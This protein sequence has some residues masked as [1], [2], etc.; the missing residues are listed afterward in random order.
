MSTVRLEAVKKDAVT[1]AAQGIAMQPASVDIWDKKYRLK[2]KKGEPVD[3]TID[4]TYKRVAKALSDAETTTEKQ[5]YWYERFLWALRRGAIPAGRITSNAGA[6]EHK[7]STS[8]INCTVSGTITDSMDGILDKVHE[9]GL[10]LKSGC[11]APGTWVVTD[12][13]LTTADLAV[14]ERHQQILS[15]DRGSGRFEMREI[16]EHLTTHVA[17]EDN[18]EIV[19]G[20]ATLTTS[21][22]HPVLVFR[23]DKTQWVR[24]DEVRGEDALVQHRFDWSADSARALDAWFAGAHLGDGSAYEKHIEYKPSRQLWASRAQ[25]AGK[26]LVFKIRA[27]ERE[28]VERYAQFFRAFCGARPQ[29]IAATTPNGTPV[30]DYMVASFAAS[31]A[32]DLIGHQTGSKTAHMHVPAWIKAQPDRHFLPFLA[33]LI[34]TDGTVS[35]EH[36]SATIAT[37]NHDFARELQALL[38]LFGVHG[39]LTLCKAR[40]HLLNGHEVR[41]NGGAMLKISDSAFLARVAEHMAD[42]GK[43]NR[44]AEHASTPGQYDVYQMPTALRAALAVECEALSAVERQ[45]NGFYHGYHLRDRVSRVWLDRWEA[46]F[47]ELKPLIAFARTLR[48]VEGIRRGLPLSETFFDFKVDG[49]NNYLAGN[50]GLL[51][52]HNCGIGY[53]FSTLRPRGAYVSGAGAYT[54]GPLSFMDIYDKMCFTVSSAGGRR[55]A[56]MGTFDVSHPDVK[57]FIGAKREDGRLRQFNLSLLITDEFMAAV[58]NDADWPLVFPV[59]VKEKDEVD[60][61]D[62]KQ[63]VWRDWPHTEMY[64]TRED[65]LVACKIF[66]HIR[67]QQLWNRI[68]ASTYDFAEPGFILIDRVNEMNNNWWCENIRA[69]NP[70]VTA[71]TRLATQYGMVRIGDL[72][73]SQQALQV[74]ADK[75]ALGLEGRGTEVRSAV[76]AFC[77]AESARVYRVVS[78]DGYEIKATEWHDFYTDRGKIKLRE[79]TVGDSLWV[80][81]GK[82][83]FGNEGSED[84]GTLLGLITGDGHFTDRGKGEDAAVISLWGEERALADRVAGIVNTMTAGTGNTEREYTVAPVAVAERNMVSI[85]SVLL[86]RA[87]KPYNFTK[88]SKLVV[89]EVIWRGSEACVKAYLRALFQTDGTVNISSRSESCSI[90]LASSEESLLKDVQ[91]LLANFGVFCRIRARRQAGQRLLP[92][93]H[94]QNKLY[95]CQAD[96]ELIVDGQSREQFMREIGFLLP[97]KN[98][99]YYGWVQDKQLLKTQRF[100]TRIARI[101]YVGEEAVYDTTQADHNTVIFNGLVTGQCGEQPLPPYG[102]CLLGSINLTNFVRHPFTDQA[103]FDNEEYKEVVRVFTRMLDNVVEVNGLPL[104]QQRA[105]IMRKRRHGMGFLGLG[106]TVTMLKMKY[107][108]PESCAFTEAVSRDMAIAGWEVA[109]ALAKEKGPAPIMDE[110]F[111]VTA[112]MLRKRPEMKKDGFKLGQTIKGREL[113][114]KYS[115]YM[116]RVASVAPELVEALSETGARFTHHSSI[117]PTG[118]ISLSLANNASNGIEPSFA[119]HYSRNVIREGKKSKEK[120]EVFSFELLAYRTLVNPDAMPYSTEEASKLPDYFIAADDITPKAHVDIQAASQK[121]IDSSISKTANVPTEYPYEDFKDIYMYAHKQG[122]KGCTTFRFN[123]AAFQGVLVKETDLENTTYRFELEDGTVVEAKG[124]EEIE[125]DGEMHSAA[126]LF[127]ALKEGYYGK[128]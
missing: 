98:D 107:G 103:T 70:C 50:G 77:T 4:D 39:A 5:K 35:R 97:A 105:E 94:G 87:L 121:W 71:D 122:L 55:G 40:T 49:H 14:S 123:P 112:E 53:E 67:A 65:G 128:F 102:A 1:E 58:E 125:Y 100:A 92:D 7:P 78:E 106:S 43:R 56:Q 111:E 119:H 33:G 32:A 41:D 68:M 91:A 73:A 60:L 99:K 24:A 57:E 34:D 28:V 27:A 3:I 83:Q 85:R 45:A 2:S 30:W 8:T 95:D 81:S 61:N 82:G 66:G 16:L 126:N 108:S 69:T 90:R 21:V 63:V 36:G 101:E 18:I 75:R 46:R 44:I 114:A 26:R 22:R 86:A 124:N 52:I 113:H 9:A 74:T 15:Y 88:D 84:L 118:T 31:K 12:R 51:V 116:Q 104:P 48:P 64:V 25:A 109:L 23:G 62:P 76:P 96:F 47:P 80:Q 37:Q 19:A 117:A 38:G 13:G 42:S 17:N 11:V 79:L 89:P 127:D 59:N 115:R 6:L 72:H 54:S 120:V 20:G 110:D 93:G 10:T 29:V